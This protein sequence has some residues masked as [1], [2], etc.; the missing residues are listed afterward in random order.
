MAVMRT[1]MGR[2]QSIAPA[3]AV[4]AVAVAASVAGALS[5]A[6]GGATTGVLFTG[7]IA[8]I[9]LLCLPMRTLVI[10][11]WIVTTIV[12]GSLQYSVGGLKYALWLPYGMALACLLRVPFSSM[13]EADPN[14]RVRHPVSHHAGAFIAAS[15]FTVIV[16]TSGLINLSTFGQWLIYFKNI[17]VFWLLAVLLAS[18]FLEDSTIERLWRSLMA[19]LVLEIP[20]AAYQN[21]VIAR[22]RFDDGGQFDAV[23]GT[24][25][26]SAT[27]GGANVTLVI[28][29]IMAAIVA[30]ALAR[31]GRLSVGKAAA[32]V[33]GAV[34]IVGL[35]EV[36]AS[37]ILLPLA[38]AVLF[39]R[40][41][42]VRPKVLIGFVVGGGL[43]LG[44]M[45]F[46]YQTFYWSRIK[47]N[48]NTVEQSV[49]SSIDY[50]TDPKGVDWKTGEVSRG[51][52]IA[53]WVSDRTKS[54]SET[55]IG[56]GPG[57]SRRESSAAAGSVAQRYFPLDI[58]ATTISLLLWDYGLLGLLSYFSIFVVGFF[59]CTRAMHR[60][61]ESAPLYPYVSAARVMLVIG[62]VLFPYNHALIDEPAV[63]MLVGLSIATA[64]RAL[65]RPA[66]AAGKRPVGAVVR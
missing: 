23:A 47:Q 45:V 29:G 32:A 50:F 59:G 51:A 38:F 26:G 22:R 14:R 6:L 24:F 10:A 25:G 53:L 36:K 66:A 34:V 62:M 21:F 2:P 13:L 48:Y 12:A 35:G 28:Y 39:G 3:M 18:R 11:T 54:V 4:F 60:I 5:F 58:A 31:A 43:V 56:Y 64:A 7:L 8:G 30:V 16:V 20:V 27:G 49:Q 44:S 9:G 41:L 1:A 17:A 19:I 63:Q 33:I 46:I 42:V 40:R 37:L 57:A 55:L 65:R 52:S 61:G 15:V